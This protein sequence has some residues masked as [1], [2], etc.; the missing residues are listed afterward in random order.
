[1]VSLKPLRE[2]VVV[3]TGASSGIRLVTARTAARAGA[4]VVLA[5]RNGGALST[6]ADEIKGQGG[7]ALAVT[8]NV[9]REED[10]G[11][12]ADAAVREFGGFDTWVNNAGVSIFGRSIDVPIEDARR[13]FDTVYWGVVY[14][15]R[16]AARFFTDHNRPGALINVGSLFGDRTTP[17]QSTYA[18]AKYAVHGWTD[19]LRM[20]LEADGAP[21]SVTLVHPGRIDTPFNEHAQSHIARQ[22]AHRGMIYPPEAVA[23]AILYAA[24]NPVRDM[25]VGGQARFVS[26]MGAAFPQLTDWIMKRYMYWSQQASERPSKPPEESALSRPGEGLHER[27]THEGWHRGTSY[28]VKMT[29]HPGLT[30]LALAGV[31]LALGAAL[32]GRG[33]RA[34][35]GGPVTGRGGRALRTSRPG[36]GKSRPGRRGPRHRGCV[37]TRAPAAPTPGGET[38]SPTTSA[39]STT[40]SPTGPTRS[41]PRSS[42]N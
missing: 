30:T 2:Q 4:A 34:G 15:S 39:P 11:R 14:G 20:E 40:A 10:V 13:M 26:L 17:V 6:L 28:Y 21:V 38:C 8:T 31:G 19:S 36:A 5:A 25:Y 33:G 9:G 42:R 22:P 29:T 27:G 1:M 24:E 3:I 16:A 12:L 23:E 18:S 7:R 37:V 41:T 35:R 32:L